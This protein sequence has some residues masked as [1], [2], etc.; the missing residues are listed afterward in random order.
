MS[1]TT[2]LDCQAFRL[3]PEAGHENELDPDVRVK[4]VLVEVVEML[5][6][7]EGS[8]QHIPSETRAEARKNLLA[9]HKVMVAEEK[10]QAEARAEAVASRARRKRKST[11][12]EE[13]G[14][15]GGQEE[16]DAMMY[17]DLTEG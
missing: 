2:Q 7:A 17:V 16:E 12:G 8:H 15:G 13:G 14:G 6:H 3:H 4:D 9:L 1:G 10:K 11:N 5:W